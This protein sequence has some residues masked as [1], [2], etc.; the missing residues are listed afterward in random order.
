MTTHKE[1]LVPS[2]SPSLLSH[3]TLNL[4]L[5]EVDNGDMK[6]MTWWWRDED[7]T[8]RRRDDDLAVEGMSDVGGLV[9]EGKS[10][11]VRCLAYWI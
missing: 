8:V 6:T 7:D 5:A 11:I 10:V 9:V 3:P 4:Y 1:P 2:L